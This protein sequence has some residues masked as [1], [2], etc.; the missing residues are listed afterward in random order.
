MAHIQNVWTTDVLTNKDYRK[1]CCGCSACEQIC[2]KSAIKMRA[3]KEMFLYPVV[4]E[5]KCI[6][7][8]LCIKACPIINEC[9]SNAPYLKTYA[10]Y[11]T[12]DSIMKHS[13]SGGFVTSLSH[14]VINKGG[15]VY[16]VTF[17]ENLTHTQYSVAKSYEELQKLAGSKY[18]QVQKDDT[19]SRIKTDLINGTF[20]LFVGCPCDVSGL[21][22]FLRKEYDNL[23]TCELVCMGVTSPKIAIDYKIWTEKTNKSK[24]VSMNMRSKEKGWFVPHL[25]EHFVNGKVK[26]ET[27][28]GTYIGYG[29]QV[30]NRPSCFF[31]QYRDTTGVGDIRVGDFWGIKQSDEFW[32]PNGVSG[33]YVRT[34]KGLTLIEE[35]KHFEFRLFE[36]D[37]I[38]ATRSNMSSFKNKP[39][40][41]RLLRDKFEHIYI[42]QGKGL[43]SACRSTA[44]ISFW[45]KHYVPDY[46]HVAL[47]SIFHLFY[48]HKRTS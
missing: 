22:R 42:E 43:V 44:S 30:F 48:D 19:F 7:C 28:F 32:N 23:L 17:N 46:F 13:T 2:S 12:D 15:V 21:K 27:L 31:C 11:S 14:L 1:D 8:G 29:F 4:D 6:D 20:V 45:I 9:K 36:T 3:D 16:G 38:L 24:L 26:C 33:I 37:Y 47:K 41:Y 40:K 5:D 39:V 35:L 10:G 18:V 25:E 34:P